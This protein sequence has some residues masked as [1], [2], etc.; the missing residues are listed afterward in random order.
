MISFMEIPKI[1]PIEA[2]IEWRVLGAEGINIYSCPAPG[3]GSVGISLS[4]TPKV[5]LK[6]SAT[7]ILK[8][9]AD[10]VSGG[11]RTLEVAS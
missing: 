11:C 9:D 7:I 5:R 4:A 1:M 3:G 2:K 8:P 6:K 10:F